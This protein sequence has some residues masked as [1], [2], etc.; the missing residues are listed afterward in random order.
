MLESGLA[1]SLIH[2]DY[3]ESGSIIIEKGENYFKFS[4][5]GNLR[6]PIDIVMEG[7]RS[8]PRNAILHQMFS[9]LGFGERAGSGLYM[10]STVWKSKNWIKPQIKEE[11]NPNRTILTL[12]MKKDKIYTNNYPNNY[13]NNYTNKLN[14]IQLQI[15]EIIKE[16]PTITA[17]E[18]SMKIGNRGLPAIKWNL[19]QLKNNG[20]IERKGTTRKGQWIIL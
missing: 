8:D 17:K 11:L 10:I 12:Y 19:K 1:N 5:P 15:I 7:G 2:A 20:T 16:N 18:I 13:T 6:I 14:K 3:S 4:N 9:Y